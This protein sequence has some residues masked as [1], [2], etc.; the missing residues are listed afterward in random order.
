[1]KKIIKITGITLAVL[2]L[3]L[4]LIPMLFQ[5]KIEEIVKAQINKNVNA[6]VNFDAVSVSLFRSFPNVSVDVQKLSVVNKAPF[7][8]DTLASVGHTYINLSL[9]S[10]LKTPKVNSIKVSEVYAN[11]KINKDSVAN[12]DIAIPSET[13]ITKEKSLETAPF[14]MAIQDYSLENINITY[15]DETG[16]MSAKVVDFNHTGAGDLSKNVLQ[17]DTHTKAKA[18]S[19]MM[20]EVA[21]LK[22]LQL[23]YDA[24]VGVDYSKD[25]QLT[26]KDNVL[27]INDLHLLF[28]GVFTLLENQYDL[29]VT[30]ASEQSKF[31]SLLSLIPNAYTTDFPKVSTTGALDLKGKVKGV[32]SNKTIPTLDLVVKTQNASVKYPDL[33]NTIQNINLD[34]HITNTT[35]KLDDTKVE[36]KDFGF[37]ILKDVFKAN[38]TVTQLES[39]PKIKANIK[40]QIDLANVKN[41]YPIP[42]LEYELKG[43]VNAAIATSFD[44]NSIEKEKFQNVQSN[45]V[46]VLKKLMLGS[47]FTPNPI[48]IEKTKLTFNTKNVSLDETLVKTGTSDISLQGTL[49]NLY[50]YLFSDSSLKGKMSVQSTMFKVSDFYQAD[51]TAVATKEDKSSEPT[52][53]SEKTTQIKFPKNIEAEATVAAKK[54]VYDN[55]ELT[56]FKGKAILKNQKITFTKADANVFGGSIA[57][58]GSVDTKPSKTAYDFDMQLKQVDIASAF[59]GMG[60]LQKIAPVIGAFNGRFDTKLDI[61]G[62]LG[63]DFMPDLSKLTGDA[64]ANLQVDKIDASQNKFLSLAE[65]KMNFLDFDK[66]DLKDLQ[67]KV[68]FKNSK[69]NIQPFTFKIKDIPVTIDGSH[70]FDNQMNYNLKLDLPAKYLGNQAASIVSKLSGAEQDQLRVPL[71]VSVGGTIGKPT[72][73]P[74]MKSAVT[75]LT[76][77]ALNNQKEQLKE[78]AADK[79]KD[80]LGGSTKKETDTTANEKSSKDNLKKAGKKILEGLFG[81]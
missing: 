18:I 68:T 49:D 26:F 51:T 42:P 16:N 15:V 40:G 34:T 57:I 46:L 6:T 75:S 52:K 77:A 9:M 79:I 24:K 3:L 8:G 17:L 20:N 58:D 74:D 13:K 72:V 59:R 22:D 31:K 63:N 11:I 25:L 54:V 67:T 65:N 36:I 33:P 1:M 14:S 50:G 10:L 76:K 70:S 32:Y 80:F 30:F 56:N 38:L 29:D 12:Y 27:H 69:V 60:M 73:V 19:L 62:I 44:L 55:M 21:Y 43:V 71:N 53:E 2:L 4:L 23:K 47:D 37:Q 64:F 39:N 61:N 78:K 81:N 41:A 7:L 48:S 35:G 5:G 45:G 66:F 28:D